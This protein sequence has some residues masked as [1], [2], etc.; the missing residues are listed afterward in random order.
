M[1]EIIR[2]WTMSVWIDVDKSMPSPNER[3]LL[4][5]LGWAEAV[6][7]GWWDKDYE[8]WVPVAGFTFPGVTHWTPIPVQPGEE[9]DYYN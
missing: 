7:V 5:R 1:V 4:L 8:E 6:T 3:V 2:D 9:D